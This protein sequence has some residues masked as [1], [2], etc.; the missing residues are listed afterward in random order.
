M[1]VTLQFLRRSNS[2]PTLVFS[3]HQLAVENCVGTFLENCVGKTINKQLKCNQVKM[4][5]L[6]CVNFSIIDHVSY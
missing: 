5:G 6:R 2:T 4:L 1:T 3:F